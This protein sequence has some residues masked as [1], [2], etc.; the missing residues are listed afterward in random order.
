M[1]AACVTFRSYSMSP[2]TATASDDPLVK[3]IVSALLNGAGAKIMQVMVIC[4]AP[5]VS[6]LAYYAWNATME[7]QTLKL[8]SINEK[9]DYSIHQNQELGGRVNKLENSVGRIEERLMSTD[10]R[11]TAL[12]RKR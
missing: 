1:T 7:I 8:N 12:E 6:G 9:L 2:I 4:G 11:I 5:V 3:R 10:A